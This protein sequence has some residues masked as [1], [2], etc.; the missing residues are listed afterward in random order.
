MP[1]NISLS[2]QLEEIAQAI[3]A[4]LRRVNTCHG[5]MVDQFLQFCQKIV[6]IYEQGDCSHQA[7]EI[8]KLQNESCLRINDNTQVIGLAV[9]FSGI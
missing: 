7:E 1:S 5:G 8:S 6:E 4:R 2:G 3:R 9:Y